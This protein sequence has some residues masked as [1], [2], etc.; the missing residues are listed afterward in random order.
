MILNENC[1]VFDTETTG[2]YAGEDEI[3]Q[4]SICTEMRK[5][6]VGFLQN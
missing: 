6:Y 5:D 4:L 2:L 3:L 1:I